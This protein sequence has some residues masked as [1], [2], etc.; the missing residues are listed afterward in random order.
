MTN[1]EFAR[2]SRGWTQDQL[3]KFVKISPSFIAL[4]EQ[5]RGIPNPDQ[6]VR[7]ARALDLSPDLLLN[8]AVAVGATA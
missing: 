7:L 8:E 5:R 4:C 2:R 3:G 6:R 1:L